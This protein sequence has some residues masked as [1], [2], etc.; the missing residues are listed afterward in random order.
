MK[1]H[2]KR[3]KVA[4]PLVTV[5]LF[6]AAV[7]RLLGSSIGGTRAA[8]TYYSETY[9]SRIQMYDIGITL[10]ENDK[11]ISWRNYSSA[12]DGTWDEGPGDLLKEMLAEGEALALRLKYQANLKVRNTGRIKEFVRVNI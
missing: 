7:G 12:G 9:T 10:V 11:E 5:V 8:L 6:V 2:K 3:M 4:S 1:K